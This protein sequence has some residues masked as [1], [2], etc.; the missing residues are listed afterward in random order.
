MWHGLKQ[1]LLGDAKS[2][3]ACVWH[4]LQS[5]LQIAATCVGFGDAQER[6]SCEARQVSAS[7]GLGASYFERYGTY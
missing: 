1:G 3:T 7:S 2:A 5:S 4:E 6:S